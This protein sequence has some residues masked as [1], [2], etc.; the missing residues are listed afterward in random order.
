MT[1]LG[2][3]LVDAIHIKGIPSLRSCGLSARN[4]LSINFTMDSLFLNFLMWSRMCSP[5][6]LLSDGQEI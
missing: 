2:N 4:F 6:V 5:K 1:D 3:V